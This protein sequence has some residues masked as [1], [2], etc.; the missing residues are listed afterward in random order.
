MA[1]LT[2]IEKETIEKFLGMG[3]GLVLDF[4]NR[5]FEE[6]AAVRRIF[7]SYVRIAAFSRRKTV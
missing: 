1:E 7:P 5:T 6:F 3:G 2:Y 4:S